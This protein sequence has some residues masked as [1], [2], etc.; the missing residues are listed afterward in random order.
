MKTDE[1]GVHVGVEGCQ[2][3]YSPMFEM[4]GFLHIFNRHSRSEVPLSARS[5]RFSVTLI[6]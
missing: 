5:T 1:V 6:D 4:F 3:G 2:C